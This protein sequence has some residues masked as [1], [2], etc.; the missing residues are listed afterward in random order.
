MSLSSLR[1][2]LVSRPH[3][4]LALSV[5]PIPISSGARAHDLSPSALQTLSQSDNDLDVLLDQ[6][7]QGL[8]LSVDD[9]AAL[10]AVVKRVNIWPSSVLTVCFGPKGSIGT[11]KALIDRIA[12]VADEWTADANVKFD[13]GAPA[14]RVC[15][16]ATSADIRVNIEDLGNEGDF[17]SVVGRRSLRKNLGDGFYSMRLQFPGSDPFFAKEEVFRFYV[18]HEFGHAL[19]FEHEHQRVNCRFDY[20]YAKSKFNFNSVE[21]VK[22]NMRKILDV[23]QHAYVGVGAISD[24]A[25]ISTNFDDNSIMKYNLSTDKSAGGDDPKIY[26][27]GTANRC[28]RSGWISSLS[29]YDKAGVRKAY[30]MPAESGAIL[31][32]LTTGGDGQTLSGPALQT[33]QSLRAETDGGAVQ[34]D[35]TELAPKPLSPSMQELRSAVER[36]RKNPLL[37]A[38]FEGIE[39]DLQ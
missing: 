23:P 38:T 6:H 31:M 16:N 14:Y 4:W 9:K 27:D 15:K 5:I 8:N 1:R 33:V 30:E 18:L 20:D 11:R 3:C 25:Y 36:V 28:Y 35:D 12:P 21:E 17:V 24:T 7:L 10:F 13:F 2:W 29:E 32:S 39:K 22:R 26:V 37:F 19:G 34:V